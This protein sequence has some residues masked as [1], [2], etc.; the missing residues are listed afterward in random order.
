V[1]AGAEVVDAEVVA[2][3]VVVVAVAVA[4]AAAAVV[5]AAAAASVERQGV[6]ELPTKATRPDWPGSTINPANLRRPN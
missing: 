3:A 2:A 1:V 5:A 6:R 4:E